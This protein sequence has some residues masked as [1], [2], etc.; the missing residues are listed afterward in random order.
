MECGT[1]GGVGGIFTNQVMAQILLGEGPDILIVN[2]GQ[3]ET[4]QE[5]GV[6]ADL[7]GIVPGESSG[8]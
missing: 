7:S 2:R 3:L 5:K 6:L 4:F 8:L 1:P